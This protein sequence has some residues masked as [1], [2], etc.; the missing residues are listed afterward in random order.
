MPKY[1]R[2]QAKEKRLKGVDILVDW[3]GEDA[4]ELAERLVKLNN[5]LKLTMITNK[6]VKVWPQGFKET[7]CT[8]H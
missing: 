2:P 8:D 6:G 4:N 7:F 5:D 1:V 3:A